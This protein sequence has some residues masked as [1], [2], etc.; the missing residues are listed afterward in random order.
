[1]GAYYSAARSLVG[2][3]LGLAS[4]WKVTGR[5]EVPPR[6]GLIIAANHISFWDPLLIGGAISREIHYLA[7][8]ELFTTPVLGP[9]IR[10]VNSIPIRRG[11]ADLSGLSRAIEALKHGGALMLFPE[12]GRMRDGELHPARPGLGMLAV[13]ADVPIA[14]CYISGSN[15]PGKWWFRRAPVRITYGRVR[16]WRDYAGRETD[17]TPGRSLYQRIGAGVMQDIAEL[18]SAQRQSASRGAA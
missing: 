7:K 17:L 11:S 1:M 10:S 3:V 6:G 2:A 12:G 5:E 13:S 8:E 15:R 18:R 14:P 16:D 9:L 4:G